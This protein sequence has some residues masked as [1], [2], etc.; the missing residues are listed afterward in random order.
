MFN[1]NQY[2][3]L[4][5]NHAKYSLKQYIKPRTAANQKAIG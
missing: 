5:N 3:H 4:I 2:R 1:I